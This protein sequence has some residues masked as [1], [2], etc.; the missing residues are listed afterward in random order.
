MFRVLWHQK[1]PIAAILCALSFVILSE[2]VAK[3][4]CCAKETKMPLVALDSILWMTM[5]QLGEYFWE[6]IFANK[7]QETASRQSCFHVNELC[8]G[9]LHNIFLSKNTLVCATLQFLRAKIIH[10]LFYLKITFPEMS[11]ALM[12]RKK[13]YPDCLLSLCARSD[14]NV[15]VLWCMLTGTAQWRTMRRAARRWSVTSGPF[16]CE[17]P[18]ASPSTRRRRPPTRN[19][20]SPSSSTHIRPAAWTRV[21]RAPPTRLRGPSTPIFLTRL[22]GHPALQEDGRRC[23][24][25]QK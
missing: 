18:S 20:R 21:L 9:F 23:A 16:W 2:N 8:F 5:L 6:R 4:S 24:K 17:P 19:P 22:T 12:R 10:P 7:F 1:F 14:G 3:P 15:Y 25:A 11:P 13:L